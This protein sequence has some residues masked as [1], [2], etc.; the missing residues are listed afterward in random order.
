MGAPPIITRYTN[1]I[2]CTLYNI[3]VHVPTITIIGVDLA[4]ILGGCM[5]SAES[6]SVP[7]GV[8]Y[9]GRD[10]P[11]RAIGDMGERREL[12]QRGPR[13]RAPAEKK[14]FWCIFKATECS[15]LYLY[16]KI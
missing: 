10:V 1:T 6:G 15:F 4:A 13:G 9:M 8:G 5:A 7:S 12:P 3:H 11:F 2:V 16:D 14:R